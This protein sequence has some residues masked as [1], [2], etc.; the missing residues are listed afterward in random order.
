MFTGLNETLYGNGDICGTKYS[1]TCL[2]AV[3]PEQPSPCRKT[4]TV[5]VTVTDSCTVEA[6]GE[7][8]STFVLSAEAFAQIAR[9]RAGLVKVAY[10]L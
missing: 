9:P 10:T 7:P 8:C 4:K 6:D 3:D 1:V 2:G 5:T